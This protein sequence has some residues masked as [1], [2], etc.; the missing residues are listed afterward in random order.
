MYSE[1]ATFYSDEVKQGA[2]DF[3]AGGC[4]VPGTA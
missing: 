1:R 3:R 4:H 2:D